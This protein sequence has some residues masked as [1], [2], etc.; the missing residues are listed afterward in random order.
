MFID[1]DRFKTI[2]DTLG[3]HVGDLLLIEV[4]RRLRETVR[5]SDIVARLG[6]DE[7]IVVL[8][9]MTDEMDA[10][11]LGDKIMRSLNQPYVFDGKELYSSPSIGIAVYPNDGEDGPTL[12]KNAD[13][14][15]YHA[16]ELGRNNV[17]YFTPA[18]NAA[19]SERLGLENDLH[20]ALRNGQ[21]HLHYQPQ[22]C[23]H[24]GRTFGVEALARW[25]HPLL[26][27]ISPLKFIPIA[28]ESGLIE[29]LGSWVL[30][31]A[32]GN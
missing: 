11:P 2:N 31:E 17:Q 8:T 10:A 13:T 32:A 23:A 1:M 3:H 4:A 26:G 9:R 14:A 28:E 19:A 12:M 7:F 30:E 25:H 21:L 15:M 22:V 5:E 20:L 16:K 24:D 29:A 18:M 6:G 27:D